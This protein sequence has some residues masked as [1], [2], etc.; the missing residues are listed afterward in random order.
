[1]IRHPCVNCERVIESTDVLA[2]FPIRCPF[3]QVNLV[4]PPA[5]TAPEEAPAAVAGAEQVGEE[6][7]GLFAM[8]WQLVRGKK[9]DDPLTRKP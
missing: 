5:S 3:C 4:V 6:D 9:S 2:G 7:P 1:M 8:I